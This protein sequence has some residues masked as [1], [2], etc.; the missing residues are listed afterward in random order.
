MRDETIK[1]LSALNARFYAEESASFSRTRTQAWPGFTRILPVVE[2]A[3]LAS[4][5]RRILDVGC[6]NGRF[7]RFLGDHV[8]SPFAYVGV[9]RSGALLVDA[10]RVLGDLR[11]H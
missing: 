6:G 3:L 9:D 4:P 1:K 10:E 2:R 11:D 5:S 7:G 8:S